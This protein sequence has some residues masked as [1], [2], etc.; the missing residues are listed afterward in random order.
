MPT[1]FSD[2]PTSLYLILALAFIIAFAIWFTQR[3]RGALIVT[4]LCALLLGA[5]IACDVLVE[6]PRE[7]A[8]RRVQAMATAATARDANAFVEH[9]SQSFSYRGA[10]REKIRTA[11]V[12]NL[13][14]EYNAR[15]AVWGFEKGNVVT[16]TAN[17]FE[18]PFFCKGEAAAAGGRP[19]VALVKATFVRDSDGAYRLKTMRFFQAIG[20]NKIE[21]TPPGFP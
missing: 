1:L 4:I 18:M 6:S 2:P 9:V 15:V 14:R 8:V 5:V 7:Q 21:E 19:F 13:I 17:E 16:I 11:N 12:W 20:D 3:T 10:G